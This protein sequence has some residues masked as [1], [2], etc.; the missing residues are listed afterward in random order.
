MEELV[1]NELKKYI[2]ENIL[3]EYELNDKG[4]NIEHIKV[5]LERAL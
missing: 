1:N 3:Q 2:K 4:H 5:V